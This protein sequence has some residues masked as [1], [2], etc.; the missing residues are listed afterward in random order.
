MIL[1]IEEESKL[2]VLSS[3]TKIVQHTPPTKANNKL[4]GVFLFVL[5]ELQI[6]DMGSSSLHL[7]VFLLMLIIMPVSVGDVNMCVFILFFRFYQE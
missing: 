3:G 2:H 7:L 4:K 6:V 5:L 1:N